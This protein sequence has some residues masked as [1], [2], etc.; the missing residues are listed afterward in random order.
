MTE[1]TDTSQNKKADGILSS[2]IIKK[3]IANANYCYNC[4]RCVT[5]CPVSYL[6]LFYP[7]NLITD[8]TFLSPEE[9]LKNNNIWEC[10]TC[11]LCTEYCP[12]TKDKVGVNFTE[13]IKNLEAL[14]QNTNP[15]KRLFVAA[16]TKESILV[17]QN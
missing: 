13:I 11:G 3:V 16:I 2:D 4:N 10:L 15:Y 12:M 6:D 9:A 5:V 17:Y 8:L 7:R 14:L 1:T